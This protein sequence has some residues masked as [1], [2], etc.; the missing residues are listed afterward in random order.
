MQKLVAGP[1]RIVGIRHDLS[2]EVIATGLTL[3]TASEIECELITD[4]SVLNFVL[5]DD[6]PS[7]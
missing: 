2:R 4:E 6:V 3:D 1:Y 7:V 5:Q